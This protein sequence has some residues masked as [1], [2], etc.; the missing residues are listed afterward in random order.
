MNPQTPDIDSKIEDVP[1]RTGRDYGKT[2]RIAE[3]NP[4]VMSGFVL[5]LLAALKLVQVDD[6]LTMFNRPK[7]EDGD[8]EARRDQA[9]D[10]ML[11]ILRTLAGCDAAAVHALIGEALQYVEV[12]A[13]PKHPTMFR[14]LNVALDIREMS[15]L[16]DVLGGFFRVNMTPSA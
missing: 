15:T 16:G 10:D 7:V 9:R 13:D 3:V 11:G 14:P 8:D 4:Y 6:L 12:A 2:Y 1:G 5:R